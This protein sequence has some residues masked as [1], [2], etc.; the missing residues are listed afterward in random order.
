MDLLKRFANSP[1]LERFAT[2]FDQKGSL[3]VDRLESAGKALLIFALWQKN[4]GPI[5]VVTSGQK[6]A[7]LE[8][9]L[10]FFLKNDL[11]SLPNLHFLEG[12]NP[13]PDLLGRSFEIFQKIG[14]G[15]FKGVILTSLEAVLC[16]SISSKE[17]EKESFLLKNGQK[18]SPLDLCKKLAQI[19]YIEQKVVSDKGQFAKR[20]GIIDLFSF[21]DPEALRVEFD[22]DSIAQMRSFD[23]GTQKSTSKVDQA[24]IFP[25][26]FQSKVSLFER[27][28]KQ[29]ILVMADLLELEDAWV[30]LKS[31][32]PSKDRITLESLLDSYAEQNLLFLAEQSLEELSSEK[33]LFGRKLEME[34]WLHPLEPFSIEAITPQDSLF[35]LARSEASKKSLPELPRQTLFLQGYLSSSICISSEHLYLVPDTEFTHQK[36]ILRQN[37]RKSHHSPIAEDIALEIGGLAVHYHHGIGK[38]L[39]VER[40]KNHLG[41]ECEFLVLA[42]AQESKL[43]VPSSQAHLVSRYVA[44]GGRGGE[45]HSLHS[46]KWQ[47]VR[48]KTENAITGY[49]KE[50]LLLHAQRQVV[51]GFSFPEDGPQMISFEE[52]FPYEETE[53][54]LSA[55]DAVK[56]DMQK[57]AAMDRLICG[58]VG[59]GKTEV[60]MRAAFKAV[61]DGHKQVAVLVPTTLLASQ[62]KDNFSSRMQPFP[63]RI[64]MLCRLQSAKESKAIL[65]DLENGKV[66]I[67]I[68]THKLLQEGVCFKDL[69]LLII[70]EEQRFGVRAKEKLKKAKA[71]VDALTLTAT[72]IPRT[73]Y[74]SLINLRQISTINSPPQDRLAIRTIIAKREPSI[75]REAILRELGRGG[76]VFFIHNRVESIEH[77]A[78]EVMALIPKVRY[79]IAHGQM[80]GEDVDAIFTHFRQGDI[81][82][83]FA[84]SLVESGID[85]QNANT[86]I[87]DRADTFG[88]SDLYQLRG[89]VGRWN[90]LAYAYFLTPLKGSITSIAKERLDALVHY[91]GFGG[92]MKLAMK[93][94]EIRG[95]GEILGTEQSGHVCAI[96]YHL[97]AKLLKKAVQALANH[98]QVSFA[99][100]K[101]EGS[102]DARIPDSYIADGSLKLEMYHRLGEAITLSMIDEI[103]EEMKDRFGEP[104]MAVYWLYHLARL[105]HLLSSQGI[106]K[107][108]IE[109]YHFEIEWEKQKKSMKKSFLISP[110][111]EPKELETI[112]WEKIRN[113]F[114]IR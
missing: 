29:P 20:A 78:S 97:Y 55:I 114:L 84:T 63:I 26:K 7:D 99:E 21:Q 110:L 103:L 94:L 80:D 67:V 113:S 30:C 58:D 2:L 91:S 73:L 13:N 90:R 65:C 96:G 42:Y 87:V 40:G 60:A 104:P 38:Y 93:D 92:G 31:L 83:L 74:L 70:D 15:N 69:G 36:M 48:A 39:G 88:M 95:G 22:D 61:M 1:S 33:E 34:R 45:V 77:V 108:K 107:L 81:D 28:S 6:M 24:K 16:T 8:A 35:V 66:D 32:P 43:Y 25:G 98:Q 50:L 75:I 56:K 100:T 109:K 27:F 111:K 49:A 71:G 19:G 53:D 82:I 101:I 86:I 57:P 106:T 4:K 18:L 17:L 52:S 102:I 51:P 79:A 12:E 89:R 59:Y 105:R 11:L 76:Q 9:D 5:V 68:G 37:F 47:Q 41:Q 23:P 10:H 46:K 54:Q 44:T 64:E 72:P 85:V 3:I 112:L 62:H 14:A